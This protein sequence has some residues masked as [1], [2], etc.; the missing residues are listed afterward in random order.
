MPDPLNPN[1]TVHLF[2]GADSTLGRDEFLRILYG[3]QVSFEVA[4]LATI[5]AIGIG[6][7]CSA[8]WPATSAAGSTPSSLA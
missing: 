7:S 2:F 8:R 1:K 4:I 6:T 3:A 5:G